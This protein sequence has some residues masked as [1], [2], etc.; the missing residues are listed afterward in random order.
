MNNLLRRFR[1]NVLLLTL[2]LSP[3]IAT[4]AFAQPQVSCRDE[5]ALRQLV[6]RLAGGEVFVG[7]L[8]RSLP[9][10]LPM[11]QGTQIV[12]SVAGIPE[13]PN[14]FRIFL[15]VPESQQQ[16]ESFY[17]QQL[18]A[19]GWKPSNLEMPQVGGFVTSSLTDVP[20]IYCQGTGG[21][22]ISLTTQQQVENQTAASLT[23]SGEDPSHY[24]ALC[25]DATGQLPQ[26]EIPLPNLYP[27]ENAQVSGD[28]GSGS[29]DAWTSSA[30]IESSLNSQQ[31]LTH[32]LQQLEQA[33]WQVQGGGDRDRLNWSYLTFTDEKGQ[34]WQAL[35]NIT[36]TGELDQQYAGRII[37]SLTDVSQ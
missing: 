14:Y 25:S 32:Y 21:L 4:S 19:A 37:A 6:C 33:G 15:T 35:L 18:Q 26:I 5:D 13:L 29:E 3:F 9:I 24:S 8:P 22:T 17:R 34:R 1:S 11:P 23:V 2:C 20:T 7:E 31:L 28:L 27:P 10:D 30:L 12:G 36:P 16:V